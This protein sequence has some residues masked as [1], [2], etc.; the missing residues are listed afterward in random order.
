IL[1]L[2]TKE[3]L[4]KI[5]LPANLFDAIKK[6]GLIFLPIT[7]E[8]ADAL[9]NF[10]SLS[11]HDPFDRILL[12]QADCEMAMLLTADVFLL[13]NHPQLTVSARK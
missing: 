1:E 7:A 2:R 13:K 10:K 4:G 11:R 9:T 5:K 3:M 6:S 8:H 12:A